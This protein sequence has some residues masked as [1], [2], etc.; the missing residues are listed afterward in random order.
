MMFSN[1]TIAVLRPKHPRLQ[2]LQVSKQPLYVQAVHMEE[3]VY[4]FFHRGYN[5]KLWYLMW[6]LHI[7]YRLTCRMIQMKQ[8]EYY[9]WFFYFSV[10]SD[11]GFP[12]A[13][14]HS[15]VKFAPE[16]SPGGEVEEGTIAEYSC[17]RGFELL[18]PARRVCTNNA[19]WS[20]QGIPFC[21]EYIVCSFLFHFQCTT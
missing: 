19:T 10:L 13:P 5:V 1:R 4:V 15:S 17:D 2:L 18:G 3:S 8:K 21:G 11:C 9:I 6:A 16:V 7:N 12:G 14:A 20:P